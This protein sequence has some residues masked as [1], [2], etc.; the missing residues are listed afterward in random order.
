MKI[1][2]QDLVNFENN[3][4]YV[5]VD[6]IEKDSNKYYYFSALSETTV[7]RFVIMKEALEKGKYVFSNLEDQ[8]FEKIKNEFINKRLNED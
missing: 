6:I 2:K 7:P 8:E 3:K 1:E 4:Q 5:V